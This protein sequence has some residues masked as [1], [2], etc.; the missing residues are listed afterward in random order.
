[1]ADTV[2]FTGA[3]RDPGSGF[4][5]SMDKLWRESRMARKELFAAVAVAEG[6]GA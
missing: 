1:M 5:E 6:G 4:A 3:W 2:P